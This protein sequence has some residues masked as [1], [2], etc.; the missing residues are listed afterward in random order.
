M[1]VISSL[2][3]N[4]A[5]RGTQGTG[6]QSGRGALSWT[7]RA[8]RS[9][10]SKKGRGGQI[11]SLGMVCRGVGLARVSG[12][13]LESIADHITD[14]SEFLAKNVVYQLL[15]IP[16]PYNLAIRFSVYTLHEALYL[17]APENTHRMSTAAL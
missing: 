2:I 4:K 17:C 12:A 7:L 9:K 1:L 15:R 11:S 13:R 10:R 16:K 5:C 14:N 6:H 8:D 3:P